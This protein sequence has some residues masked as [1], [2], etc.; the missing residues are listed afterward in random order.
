M[1]F[2]YN[3]SRILNWPIDLPKPCT[4][5]PTTLA[6]DPLMHHPCHSWSQVSESISLQSERDRPPKD[7]SLPVGGLLVA[8]PTPTGPQ[9]S[10]LYLPPDSILIIYI[11]LPHSHLIG[12]L[13]VAHAGVRIGIPQEQLFTH[14][15]GHGGRGDISLPNLSVHG[16]TLSP[17]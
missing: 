9:L 1:F 3:F 10:A 5:L 8:T 7:I 4:R 16:T 13:L 11:Y 12:H 6:I 14:R 2:F 15:V 17:I